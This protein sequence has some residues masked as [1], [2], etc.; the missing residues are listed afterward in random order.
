[1][2]VVWLQIHKNHV[3]NYLRINFRF[4]IKR[5]NFPSAWIKH[6]SFSLFDSFSRTLNFSIFFFALFGI[7]DIHGRGGGNGGDGG[8]CL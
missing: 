8:V 1:M 5:E 2:T 6:S 3:A 7:L 4:V